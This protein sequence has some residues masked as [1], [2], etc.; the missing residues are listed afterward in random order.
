MEQ[1][2]APL[3][4]AELNAMMVM[5]DRDKDNMLSFEGKRSYSSNP[6]SVILYR[7]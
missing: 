5:A 1:I 2:N 3:T 4:E 7:L 6:L